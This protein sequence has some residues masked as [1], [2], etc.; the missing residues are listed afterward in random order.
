MKHARRSFATIMVV[1]LA[2]GMMFAESEMSG[3][4]KLIGSTAP[5]AK[6]EAGYTVKMPFLQG[7]GPL[8]SGNNV[9]LKGLMGI[10]PIAATLSM[11]A[12]VTPVAVLELSLGG[13]VGTGWN[14]DLMELQG[15]A[16]G[17]GIADATHDSLGGVYYKGRAGAALQF[18]TAAIWPGDW[19]SVV[20]R[21]YHEIN[22]QGY[23]NATATEGWEFETAGLH[24][25]GLNYKGDYLVGYQ[26]PL[27]VNMAALMLETYVD[28]MGTAFDVG[29]TFDLGLVANFQ[30]TDRLSLTVI[31]QI[32]NRT[33][34][35]GTRKMGVRPTDFKRV[36]AMLNYVL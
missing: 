33:I 21:T 32:S 9:K 13:A 20:M 28:N 25:N 35:D 6:V 31:P 27:L 2:V 24:L 7:E 14:F 22:Y 23:S 19:T 12:V 15:L 18:D 4:L 29:M 8:F 26:M 30:F 11:D 17:D 36:A 16:K 34:A 1:L 3:N 10:S 5:E